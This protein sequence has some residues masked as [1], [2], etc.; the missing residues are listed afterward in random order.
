MRLTRRRLWR[1]YEQ[2]RGQAAARALQN[3]KESRRDKIN[4]RDAHA[5]ELLHR[6]HHTNP[7]GWRPQT[8]QDQ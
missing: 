6:L 2:G 8:L 7:A 1:C 4:F 3:W 5:G